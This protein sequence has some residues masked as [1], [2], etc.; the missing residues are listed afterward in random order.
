MSEIDS[1]NTDAVL[2]DQNPP[3]HETEVSGDIGTKQQ[4]Q[5]E[6]AIST[7][8][9]FWQ[10]FEYLDGLPDRHASIFADRQVVNFEPGMKIVNPQK[11]AYA[12]REERGWGYSD[13]QFSLEDRGY[14]LLQDARVNEVEALVFGYGICVSDYVQFLVELHQWFD[15][16]KALFLGDIE[17]REQIISNLSFGQDI[18]PI[19]S[20]Y[21]D[22]E[23]LQIRCGGYGN[24]LYF[25]QGCHENLKVLRIES[26]GLNRS[27][28][29]S[30][31]QLE[32]P[33]LEYL[34]LWT[35][36]QEYGSDSTIEDVMPIISGERFPKLK[37]LGIKNCEYTNDVVV[38]LGN[39]SL[40]KSLLELDL[41][42]GTLDL[43][44]FLKLINSRNFNNIDKLNIDG[45]CLPIH[46]LTPPIYNDITQLHPEILKIKCELTAN[47]QR[48]C[49]DR[50]HRHC[51]I[52]E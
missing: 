32:L 11:T 4:L 33:A 7:A 15:G 30:L 52:R 18:S 22:L 39:S 19:L 27:A 48:S 43:E 10:N 9:K 13:R 40:M 45:N 46:W 26:S 17:D 20:A 6:Q 37:Y 23:I 25:S 47:N 14:A 12:L 49:F 21:P 35:G 3:L 1:N 24:G 42:M 5:H 16:L 50:S 29:T 51:S 2:G 36:S 38:E 44:G 28:I 31:C 34:E 41:S 8:N